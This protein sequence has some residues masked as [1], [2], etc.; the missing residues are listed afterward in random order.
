MEQA[1]ELL[2]LSAGDAHVEPLDELSRRRAIKAAV[3]EANRPSAIRRR[4]SIPPD[5]RS[6]RSRRRTVALVAIGAAAAMVAA[7]IAGGAALLLI[8][9][10]D[11]APSAMPGETPAGESLEVS[12]LLASGAT[13][14]LTE[15]I[16]SGTRLEQGRTISVDEGR[17]VVG[18]ADRVR[19]LAEPRTR[20]R[21]ERLD[22]TLMEVVLDS[23]RVL[24]SVQPGTEEPRVVVSTAAGKVLVTGTVFAVESAAGEVVVQVYRG[25]VRVERAGE[26]PF[27]VQ[28]PNAADLETGEVT[29]L[30][31]AEVAEAGKTAAAMEILSGGASARLQVRSVPSG[32][33]VTLDGESLGATPIAM[34]VRPGHRRLSLEL[35]RY[36]P[37]AEQIALARDEA[38]TR[39]FELGPTIADRDP[40][41]ERTDE[42]TRPTADRETPDQILA[43]AQALRK[44]RDWSGAARAY[45][46]LVQEFPRSG[47]A[48][49]A[50][51]SLGVIQL[52]H[53]GQAGKA[54]R[55]FDAY[56]RAAPNGA[57]APEA[58]YGRASAF[59]AQDRT[60]LEAAALG[61]L[62]ARFPASLRV[63]AARQRL[64]QLGYH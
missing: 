64:K 29:E 49:T 25:T 17:A 34:S 57:L 30:L 63:P 3:D 52:R 10:G 42:D 53:L 33:W 8:D 31:D 7:V 18:I 23:G 12:V 28:A 55:N 19:M 20:A 45:S 50:R 44:K 35:E 36:A 6:A 40:A 54:L 4:S 15:A 27:T 32:A 51:V 43:R 11:P 47:Q 58:I 39:V 13:S 41:A 37:M 60:D 48:R 1:E 38:V 26:E 22:R 2:R 46:Q 9:S 16:V 56:L 62:V 5:P 61:D 21:F 14:E 24:L 59:R